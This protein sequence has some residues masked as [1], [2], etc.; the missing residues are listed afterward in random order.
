M[1]YT[2]S[3]A[4]T[5]IRA[6][7]NEDTPSFWS[8]ADLT[9]WVKQG[10]L[11]W[12][13]KSLLLLA[14]DT[15]TLVDGQHQYTTSDGSHIDTATRTIHAEYND[16]A[17]QRISFEQIRGHNSKKIS[18]SKVPTYYFD[19]YN[20]TTFTFYIGPTPDSTIAGN[21]ITC[22]FAQKTDDITKIPYEY[23]QT[24]FLYAA[25]KAKFRERQYQEASLYYQQYIN[26][27]TFARQDSLQRGIQ[28][29][30]SFRIQ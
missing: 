26:N 8:D 20:G 29:T 28:P 22:Y 3:T 30:A 1:A 18:G 10:C 24:V 14:E 25:S 21:K 9:E 6:L 17:I 19:M 7:I 2:L 11:D 16:V 12:S 13:E 4:I 23:Q 15:I 5:E 27:I